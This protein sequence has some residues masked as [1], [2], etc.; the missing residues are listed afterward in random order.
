MQY[1]HAQLAATHMFVQNSHL[2]YEINL[3]LHFVK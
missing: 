2:L 3:F 1:V